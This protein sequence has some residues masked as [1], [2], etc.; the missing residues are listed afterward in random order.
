[1]LEDA[2]TYNC[3]TAYNPVYHSR[4]L[5]ISKGMYYVNIVQFSGKKFCSNSQNCKKNTNMVCKKLNNMLK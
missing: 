5:G 3:G 2:L 4:I 1:M